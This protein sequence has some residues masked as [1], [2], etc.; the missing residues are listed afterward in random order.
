VTD[1]VDK[2]TRSRMMAGIRGKNTLPEL[3]VRRGL[4]KRGFRYK[5]HD[6]R[7]PGAPDLV[8]PK[9]RAVIFVHG[10]FWHAHETCTYFRLPR[11]NEQFWAAKISGNCARDAGARALLIAAGWRVLYI[12]ECSLR[13]AGQ[14]ARADRVNDAVATWLNSGGRW[15]QIGADGILVDA[16][17]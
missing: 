2:A 6:R 11:T 12:W 17:S 7:L 10:C 1:V 15:S 13:G 5:L 4:H 16:G 3:L 14:A 8:F 9:R